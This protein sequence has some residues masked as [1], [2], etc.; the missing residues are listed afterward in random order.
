MSEIRKLRVFLSYAH[1]DIKPVR[2]LYND[3][4]RQGYDVWF[5][6]ESLIPG[7]NWQSAI[8]KA[9]YSS[10][11]VI[12]CLSKVSVSKEGYIQKEFKFALDKALEMTEDGIFLVPARLEECA[13]PSKLSQYHW[14]DLFAENGFARLSKALDSRASQVINRK[15]QVSNVEDLK[16]VSPKNKNFELN[17]NRGY[18]VDVVSNEKYPFLGKSITI[19]RKDL[20][21]L[22]SNARNDYPNMSCGILGGMNSIVKFVYPIRN[23]L[24]S[25][26]RFQMDPV[27]QLA[28]FEKIE[29]NELELTS[30][31]YSQ[32]HGDAHPSTTS[33]NEMVYQTPLVV[34]SLENDKTY[35][36]IRLGIFDINEREVSRRKLIIEE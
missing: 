19:K 15:A 1:A 23:V 33:I 29:T 25:T 26:T 24:K 4:I 18:A 6:E 11:L 8:E 27:G 34:I 7:Q 3:L 9:L 5:D 10:D 2:K 14:V 13:V 21:Y 16:I 36:R 28:A 22:I 31:Y 20:D 17:L 30:I 35:A 12:V 32:P